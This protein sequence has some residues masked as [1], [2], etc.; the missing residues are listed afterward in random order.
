MGRLVKGGVV[1]IPFLFSDLGASKRRLVLVD[2][3]V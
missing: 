3:G 1:V 2:N